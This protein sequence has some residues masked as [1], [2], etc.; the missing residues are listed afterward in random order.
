MSIR[1]AWHRCYAHP[2]PD[3]HRFPMEKYNLIPEQLRHEGT[4]S[5]NDFFEP[6]V[7]T[8]E[9]ILLTHKKDYWK[10]L[11]S[12]QLTRHE[13][14]VSGFPHSAELIERERIIA[15]GTL[16]GALLA[17]DGVVSLNVAGGTHHAFRGRAE[18]FCLL[19]GSGL[20][21]HDRL[22]L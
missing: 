14:R 7:M 15:K 4:A 16:D 18:G 21:S 22:N 1:I 6:E 8:E 12:L 10:R 20:M 2:L 17:L 19:N 9:T 13:Q 5:T 3:N 11:N